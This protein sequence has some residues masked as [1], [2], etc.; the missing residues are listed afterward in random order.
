MQAPQVESLRFDDT[1]L[2]LVPELGGVIIGYS[3]RIGTDHHHWMRPVRLETVVEKGAIASSS[4]PLVPFSNRIAQGRFHYDGREITLPPDPLLPPHAIHGH[5][6]RA[7]WEVSERSESTMLLRYRHRADD[8]PWAY[9]ATQRCGL[10][11]EGLWIEMTLKNLSEQPM[12]AGLG[13]HPHF[14]RTA[15]VRLKAAVAQAHVADPCL[16]PIAKRDDHPAIAPLGSG[17]PLPEGLDLC[18]EGWDGSAE[19]LWPA[20]NRGL[21]VVA[22]PEFGHL[23]IFTPPDEDFFCVEPVSHCVNAVNL[24]GSEWGVTG[25]VHLAPGESVSAS[26]RFQPFY[27][28]I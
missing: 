10:D 4:Y 9:E 25:L 1:E 14:P 7:A 22:G 24:E 16:L 28:K 6:W 3:S 26:A 12:P 17:G 11:A 20:E 2:H 18:F 8:W 19:I 13:L 5:G 15:D 21:R 23:V 27:P